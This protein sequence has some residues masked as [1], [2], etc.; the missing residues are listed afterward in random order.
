[1]KSCLRQSLSHL[2]RK[3]L[4]LINPLITTQN[5]N[6]FKTNRRPIKHKIKVTPQ[7]SNPLRNRFL[8]RRAVEYNTNNRVVKTL[9]VDSSLASHPKSSVEEPA[10]RQRKITLDCSFAG[11]VAPLDPIVAV[12]QLGARFM[13]GRVSEDHIAVKVHILRRSDDSD[14]THR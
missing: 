13:D 10:Y 3:L 6:T 12:P 5:R 11:E 8:E 14:S 7:L 1:M 2:L 9:I 4:L